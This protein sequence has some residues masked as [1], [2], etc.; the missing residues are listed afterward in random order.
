VNVLSR[1]LRA[2][3]ES[4]QRTS[5]CHQSGLGVRTM[6]PQGARAAELDGLGFPE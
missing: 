5:H 6:T 4:E 3:E 2:P 1:Q